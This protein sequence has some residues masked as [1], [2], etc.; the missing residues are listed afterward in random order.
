MPPRKPNQVE[1]ILAKIHKEAENELYGRN[2]NGKD[3]QTRE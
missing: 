1:R 2:D 3:Q